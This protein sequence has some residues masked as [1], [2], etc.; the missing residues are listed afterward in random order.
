VRYAEENI[1]IPFPIR[2]IAWKAQQDVPEPSVDLAR[3]GRRGVDG[4]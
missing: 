3:L 2:T 1:E 4:H